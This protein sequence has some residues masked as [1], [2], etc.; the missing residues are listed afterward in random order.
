MKY[1][2]AS[3][4]YVPLLVDVCIRIIEE[5]GLHIKGIY[6][7]PGNTLAITSLQADIEKVICNFW[8]ELEYCGNIQFPVILMFVFI[9]AV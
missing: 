5:K 1:C 2:R 6:R 4:Q 3:L 7:V 9:C 8:N